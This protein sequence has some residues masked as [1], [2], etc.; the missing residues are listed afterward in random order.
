MSLHA[1]YDGDQLNDLESWS[2]RASSSPLVHNF[3]FAIGALVR[4]SGNVSRAITL[5][6][7]RL[8]PSK[9]KTQIEALYL[10]FGELLANGKADLTVE[11]VTY[12]DAIP[13]SLEPE[14]VVSNE[15]MRYSLTFAISKNQEVFQPPLATG[16]ARIGRFYGYGGK[17]TSFPIFDNFEM[18]PKHTYAKMTSPRVIGEYG[19]TIDSY[20]GT[21]TLNLSCWAVGQTAMNFQKYMADWC[22]DPIGRMGTLDL[23]GNVIENCIMTNF[24]SQTKIGASMQ[25]SVNFQTSV[26]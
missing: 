13:L 20:G 1:T 14:N 3:P 2:L 12:K 4:P 6:S 26:C 9:T 18:V 17:N 25:Y 21:R 15:Y 16:R 22:I 11:G 5:R 10:A 8:P 19:Q 24:N 23:N 7:I